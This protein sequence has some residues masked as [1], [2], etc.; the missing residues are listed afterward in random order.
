M[1]I[2]KAERWFLVLW[3]NED[4]AV[5]NVKQ[6]HIVFPDVDSS[7][8]K[9]SICGIKYGRKIQARFLKLVSIQAFTY[10]NNS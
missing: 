1:F 6:S 7:L 5:S 8:K 2:A 9:G 4:G 10:C 3:E